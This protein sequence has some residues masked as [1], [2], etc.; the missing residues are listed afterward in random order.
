MYGAPGGSEQN[1]ENVVVPKNTFRM[2]CNREPRFYISVLYNEA[3]HW[4]K[5]HRENSKET[6]TDFFSGGS[7]GGPSHDS[8]S[9]GYLV[10]KRVDPTVVEIENGGTYKKRH[11]V[12]YRLAEA[13]LSYAECLNEYSIEKGTYGADLPEILR[14]LNKIRERAGIPTYGTAAGQIVPPATGEELR[15]LIRRERRVELNC[16]AGIRFDDVRRWKEAETA[17]NGKFYGMNAL[18]KKD[19]RDEYYK[20]TAYQ[21]RKFISYWWPIPQDDIDKNT[22]LRQLPGWKK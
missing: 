11:G 13:Y 5:A 3:Y 7:D 2:Y 12:I 4:G 14:Y 20:R 22:N 6:T 9:A 18:M 21:T 1:S 17:L 8:P 10:R 19:A 15:T 16:E